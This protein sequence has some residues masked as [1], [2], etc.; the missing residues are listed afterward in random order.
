MTP[1]PPPFFKTHPH[2]RNKF[3]LISLIIFLHLFF[4]VSCD[5]KLLKVIEL[6]KKMCVKF[7]AWKSLNLMLHTH[8]RVKNPEI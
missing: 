6:N 4:N 3:K 8:T 5:N 7:K 2:T 1:K